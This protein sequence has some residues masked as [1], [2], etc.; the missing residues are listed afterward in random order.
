MNNTILGWLSGK[1]ITL[2]NDASDQAVVTAIQ[3][4]FI[5]ALAPVTTLANEK[6]VQTSTITALEN[7]KLALTGR[8]TALAAELLPLKKSRA[9][10]T[11]DLA[12]QRGRLKVGDRETKITAL[13]NSANF[14]ADAEALMTGAVVTKTIGGSA[15]IEEKKALA[16]DMDQNGVRQTYLDA[17]SKHMTEHPDHGAVE[18]HAAVMKAHPALSEAMKKP[19]V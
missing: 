5:D 15:G 10:L 17:L 1:G 19:T 18:A 16:N 14:D 8:V 9:A 12:I 7:E 11:A 13:E 4:V 2:S 3:K 6:E